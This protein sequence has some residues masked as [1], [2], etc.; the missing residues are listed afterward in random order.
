MCIVA[1]MHYYTLIECRFEELRA[2]IQDSLMNNPIYNPMPVYEQILPQTTSENRYIDQPMHVQNGLEV[3]DSTKMFEHNDPISQNVSDTTEASTATPSVHSSF[4]PTLTL[5]TNDDSINNSTGLNDGKECTW[6]VDI[7]H[8]NINN[9][10]GLNDG[11][12]D[13][14]AVDTNDDSINNST[15]FNDGQG[16]TWSVDIN[17]DSISNSTDFNDGKGDAWSVDTND[18][19]IKNLTGFNDDKE[20]TRAVPAS[21][22]QIKQEAETLETS[23]TDW[24]LANFRWI[25]WWIL[26]LTIC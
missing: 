1:N 13:T 19:S 16:D 4:H 25:A 26:K 12:E 21:V 3:T 7:Y 6:S 23:D 11:K 10:T 2:R 17:N 18:D 8:D 22:T 5:D 9:S 14:Q 15:C 20:G 24:V